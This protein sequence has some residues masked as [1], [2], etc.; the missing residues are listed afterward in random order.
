[1]GSDSS[2]MFHAGD[3]TDNLANDLGMNAA[4]TTENLY[5]T[6]DNV[7]RIV[8]GRQTNF[9]GSKSFLFNPDGSAV[10]DGGTVLTS[11]SSIPGDSIQ[12]GTIDSSEIQDNTLTANDLAANSV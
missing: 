8:A 12:D 3:N 2:V 6:A 4:S 9:A 10:F 11:L 5:L 1:M 7:V